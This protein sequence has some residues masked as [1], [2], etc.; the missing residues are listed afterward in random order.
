MKIFRGITH[1]LSRIADCLEFLILHNHD[2]RLTSNKHPPP[3]E[4]GLMDRLRGRRLVTVSYTDQEEVGFKEMV[5]EL[6]HS[7]T[8]QK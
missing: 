5:E 1:Q 4:P 8:D 2:H 6:E 3:P 7:P